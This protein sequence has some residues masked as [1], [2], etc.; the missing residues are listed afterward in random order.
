[1]R[2]IVLLLSVAI[3]VVVLPISA[4]AQRTRVLV[5]HVPP[6]NPSNAQS[7]SLPESAVQAHLAHGDAFGRCEGG[8][9]RGGPA[10]GGGKDRGNEPQ[11]KGGDQT[12][13]EHPAANTRPN[14]GGGNGGG[15]N[16]RGNKPET[17]GGGQDQRSRDRQLDT[18][19]AGNSG[20]GR[21]QLDTFPA[22]NQGGGGGDRSGRGNQQQPSGGPQS[23][24]GRPAGKG[25][26]LDNGGGNGGRGSGN[27]NAPG[28]NSGGGPAP[29]KKGD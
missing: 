14:D 22:G 6:G 5:C 1:M 15:R 4:F 7:L 26:H 11:V 29:K 21:K 20:G 16:E 17:G 10:A 23:G 28:G 9:V 18:L 24:Q 3:G 13:Q 12:A 2:V 8:R 19:P 25:P 27:N